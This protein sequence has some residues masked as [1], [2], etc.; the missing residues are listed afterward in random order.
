MIQRKVGA[1]IPAGL[2]AISAG[3]IL[4][5][6]VVRSDFFSGLLLGA[7]VALIVLGFVRQRRCSS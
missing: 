7:G 1:F 2:L 3:I 6:F 5:L 4:R